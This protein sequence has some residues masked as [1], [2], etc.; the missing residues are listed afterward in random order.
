M[1]G[2]DVG[3]LVSWQLEFTV[4]PEPHAA[5]LCLLAATIWAFKRPRLT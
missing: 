4:V 1:E 2:G 3:T 5:M